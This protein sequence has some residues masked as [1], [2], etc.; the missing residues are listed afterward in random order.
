VND[1]LSILPGKEKVNEGEG[2]ELI[3]YVVYMNYVCRLTSVF[4][5]ECMI[6]Y[7]WRMVRLSLS[8][9]TRF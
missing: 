1:L 7:L 4:I 5:G 8:T 2:K 3:E 6:Q 9:R